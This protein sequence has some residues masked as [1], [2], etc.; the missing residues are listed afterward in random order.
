MER[1]TCGTC[2]FFVF[3]RFC[4]RYPP[5]VVVFTDADEVSNPLP[6][7]NSDHWCGEHP[8][9]PAYLKATRRVWLTVAGLANHAGPST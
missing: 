3:D 8:D 6:Q 1:P 5:Q 9:F 7:V 2:P 4:R